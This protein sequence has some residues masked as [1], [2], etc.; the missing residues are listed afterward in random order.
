MS[1]SA[2][3]LAAA[4]FRLISLHRKILARELFSGAF[5][6]SDT[7][8]PHGESARVLWSVSGSP[9]RRLCGAVAAPRSSSWAIVGVLAV[10]S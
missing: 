2:F 5:R 3:V 1:S 9:R 7:L 8:E 4:S 10:G 6:C